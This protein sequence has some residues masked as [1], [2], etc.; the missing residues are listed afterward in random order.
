[1]N[2]F[3]MLMTAV[4]LALLLTTLFRSYALS[5]NLL[6]LPNPR[7]S[8]STPT[9]RGGGVA[10]AI[11]FLVLV[12]LL[13]M[14]GDLPFSFTWAMLGGGICVALIGFIDD[15]KHVAISL[16]LLSHFVGAIWGLYWLGGFPS[17]TIFG[18][19]LN[20]GWVGDL[21]AA[22]FLVWLLNLYN[23]MDGIDGI[24]SIEAITVCISVSLLCFFQIES[25]YFWLPPLLLAF[26]VMGFLYWNFPQAKIFMGDAGSGFIGFILGL[27]S[28]QAA[29]ESTKMFWVWIILLSVFIVDATLTLFQRI[30]KGEEFYKAHRKHAYQVAASQYGSHKVVS[31][32]IGVINLIWLLPVAYLVSIQWI[33]GV[34]GV[35]IAL[36]PLVGLFFYF[37]ENSVGNT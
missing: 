34:L 16:R 19:V 22:V 15:H 36:T 17:L 14:K 24:A 29:W 33:D 23:F 21:L 11:T 26:T 27:F 35:I 8:H 7:G 20:L 3:L 18:V 10:I 30:I 31:L 37:R 12:S 28:I 25:R 2:I 32:S 9:P 5:H 6:D 1:M 13:C 4:G